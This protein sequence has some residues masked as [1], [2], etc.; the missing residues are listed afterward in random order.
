MRRIR[1]YGRW[2]MPIVLTALLVLP[3]LGS[4]AMS[5]K[6]WTER[7]AQTASPT[8]TM[9][10]WS[11]IAKAAKPAVVNLTTKAARERADARGPEMQAP[12]EFREQFRDFFKRFEFPKGLQPSQ[13]RGSGFIIHKDGYILTNNHVIDGAS[14]VTVKLSDGRSC[15][16]EGRG[17]GREDRHRAPEDRRRGGPAGAAAR[18]FRGARDR[19]AGHGHRQ[20]LR[21]RADGHHRDRQ[22][23]RPG[24]RRRPLRRLRP[25]RRLDQSRQQRRPADQRPGRGDRHEHRHLQPHRRLGRHRLRGPDQHG[26]ARG[27]RSW[28]SA[29]GSS[30]GGSA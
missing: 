3:S 19:R 27:R 9:P 24:D 22:R 15:H 8:A 30:A 2:A 12:E 13:G 29:G 1:P 6:L 4:S 11:E 23:H 28:R 7:P 17:P 10:A 5:G 21:P 26:Q 16:G 18:G 20:S 14:E 25:D